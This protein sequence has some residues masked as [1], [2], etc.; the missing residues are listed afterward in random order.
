MS[1]FRSHIKAVL[2]LTLSLSLFAA[3]GC[4]PGEKSAAEPQYDVII[5][6]GGM[7]GLSAGAHLASKGLKVL[8]LEQHHKVG[9]CTTNFTR[10]DFTFEVALH[11]LAGGGLFQLMDMCGVKDK[12]E[13][14]QLP[15]LY[16]SIFPGETVVDVTM[17]SNWEGWDN[18]LKARWPEESQG[19]D[20]LH[21]LSTEV[22]ADIMDIKDLFRYS[23]PKKLLKTLSVP[24]KHPEL[25]KWSK[26]T[27]QEL[28]DYCF[29]NQDIKAVAS[30]FWIYYGAPIPDEIALL[31]LAANE[32]FLTEGAWHVKG[33]SQV[34]SN[35]YAERI[36]ELGGEVKTGTLVTK[37]IVED[38]VATGV[39][40]EYGDIY[41]G[42][43]VICDTD[44]YQMV[45]T[46][47]GKDNFPKSYVEKLEKLRPANSLFVT[48]LGL[49][50]DLKKL[51]YT[52]TE[53]FYNTS[54]DSVA[55]YDNMMKNNF[56]EGMVSITIYS[57][58]GDPIYAPPGKSLVC[59]LEFSDYDSWP[60]DREQYQHMKDEKA[61][62]I[63]ALAANV[64]PELADPK[65]V[66]VMEVMT[67]VTL[68][69]F[70]MNYHGIP[71]GFYI[72][73]DQWKKIPI[74]TPIDNLYISSSWTQSWHGV[75]SAQI[76]GWMAARLIMDRE[77][78]E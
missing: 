52:G 10:G 56:K 66:D 69:E 47:V 23:G 36:R 62:E 16:R 40:T 54:K 4:G 2:I 35:A 3:N 38:G 75:G 55:V 76:N 1:R 32:V 11:E 31:T 68:Q 78:I 7:A 73:L 46:L 33:T 6:G 37:I 27:L 48:Y 19:V 9:G 58:Y 65:N 8:L 63:I 70:T 30:Q 53:I 22:F 67:P 26:R 43:Y 17:P 12:V 72:D 61:R 28:M 21:R 15:E 51:G 24:I 5:V 42:R 64:I 74:N 71:Y 44:P 57:N 25:V 13:L 34:L 45:F 60:K 39:Q 20:K 18:T 50:I 59:L 41:T 49:N 29:T 77:G 14:Y